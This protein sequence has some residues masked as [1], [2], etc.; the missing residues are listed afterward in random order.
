MDYKEL[1]EQQEL[2]SPE[3]ACDWMNRADEAIRELVA[4]CKRLDEARERA[5]EAAHQWEGRCKILETRLETAEKMVKEY[6]DIIVPGYRER[7]EKAEREAKEAQQE[8]TLCRNGWK[9]AERERDAAAQCL[10]EKCIHIEIN[11]GRYFCGIDD[12]PC[13]RCINVWSEEKGGTDHVPLALL[14]HQ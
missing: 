2:N 12:E 8:A 11:E 10:F 4:R 7:A 3:E 1:L 6:Q 9:K 14:V 13:D 5:N